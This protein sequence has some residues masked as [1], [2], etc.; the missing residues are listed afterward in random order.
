MSTVTNSTELPASADQ[1]WAKL[2]NP[3]TYGEWLATHAGLPDGD[4]GTLTTGTT[5]KEKVKIMGMPGEVSWTVE[6]AVENERLVLD[7]K[8][9]MGTKM[10]AAYRIVADGGASTT[11]EYEAEF[12]GAALGP[13]MGPLTKESEKA[14]TESLERLKALLAS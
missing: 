8:G 9:P 6:E 5:Y 14:A 7:G 13:M 2:A 12:G 3:S 1:V 11:V 10:R 4:P